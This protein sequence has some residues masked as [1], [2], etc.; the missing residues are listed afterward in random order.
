[1]HYNGQW[2][3]PGTELYIILVIG[4]ISK[5][6]YPVTIIQHLRHVCYIIVK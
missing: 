1:M 5:P 3:S 6:V 4:A 2:Q